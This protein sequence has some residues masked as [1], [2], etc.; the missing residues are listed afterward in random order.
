VVFHH[1]NIERTTDLK[2][3]FLVFTNQNIHL[4]LHHQIHQ[5]LGDIYRPY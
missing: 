4:L 1:L 3:R 5:F 2:I